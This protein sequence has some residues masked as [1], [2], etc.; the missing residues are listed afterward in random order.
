MKKAGSGGVLRLALLAVLATCA[1]LLVPS[2]ASAA[3]GTTG[4]SFKQAPVVG[5][6]SNGKKFYGKYTVERFANRGGQVVAIGKLTGKIGNRSVS[7]DGVAMPVLVS[8][9][10]SG[11]AS[12]SATCQILN[13]TLG[14]LDLNLLGLR[15]QLNQ[16][17]LLITAISGPGNLLGNLLCGVAG[18][19]DNNSVLSA[20]QVSQLLNIVLTLV[21][22][23]GL[24]NL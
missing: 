11:R 12:A 6:A 23:P 7:K 16:V 20:G 2:A 4:Q 5:Q 21:N 15:V 9:T 18:L 13:L 17:H 3:A 22:N 1:A 10:P 14:P 19:L 8:S 24:L